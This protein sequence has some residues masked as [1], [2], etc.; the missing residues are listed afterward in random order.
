MTHPFHPLRGREFDVVDVRR[1]WGEWRVYVSD[2]TGRLLRLPMAWTDWAE[3]DPFQLAS[4]GRSPL[5]VEDLGKL[6]QLV[7]ALRGEPGCQEN[8]A[9]IDKPNLPGP[10]GKL[11]VTGDL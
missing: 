8:D 1:T 5:H 2:E 6:V 9:E 10:E 7:A 4:G 3:P 11:V